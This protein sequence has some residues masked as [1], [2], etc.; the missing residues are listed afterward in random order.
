MI[1][2]SDSEMY[3]VD[4]RDWICDHLWGH[5]RSI[6]FKDNG[7]PASEGFRSGALWTRHPFLLLACTRMAANRAI[8]PS[9]QS[10]AF[11]SYLLKGD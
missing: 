1:R 3:D 2:G 6:G 10:R 9:L 5:R 8:V 11:T 4:L 7:H